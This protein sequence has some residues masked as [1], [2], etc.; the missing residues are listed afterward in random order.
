MPLACNAILHCR[1]SSFPRT[2]SPQ[3]LVTYMKKHLFILLG[4]T[5]LAVGVCTTAHAA[6]VDLTRT[7]GSAGS[8]TYYAKGD[9]SFANLSDDFTT[10]FYPGNGGSTNAN[11]EDNIARAT[12]GASA[13]SFSAGKLTDGGTNTFVT[14]WNDVLGT[15]SGSSK[16]TA[17]SAHDGSFYVLFDLGNVYDLS[18]VVITYTN[19]SGQRWSDGIS[20]NVYTATSFTGTI[21]DFTFRGSNV[22]DKN[23]TTNLTADYSLTSV[24][25]R[26]V[27][28]EL[29]AEVNATGTYSA[30]GGK[31]VEVSI[32]G[33]STPSAV[34]EPATSALLLG[35]AGLVASICLRR[36]SLEKSAR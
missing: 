27:L 14:G 26:Y 20:Q 33:D 5:A 12:S 19:A 3:K 11:T 16:N 30:L 10:K 28:L 35:M 21:A 32:M 23:S 7:L 18:Q 2:R 15:A 31:L 9:S 25:A 6:I 29:S 13:R 22:F 1:F 8:Y 4:L 17:S 34:P 36:H 24:S